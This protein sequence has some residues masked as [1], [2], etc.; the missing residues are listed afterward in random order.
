MSAADRV[1]TTSVAEGFGLVFLEPWLSG[2]A[3][4][5][6]DLPEITCDF[7]TAGLRFE[8]LSSRLAIPVDW[9]GAGAFRQHVERW[10]AETLVRY[11]VPAPSADERR[12]AL[13]A[14]MEGGHVDFATLTSVH[15][16]AIIQQVA[17]DARRRHRLR[18]LNA[19]VDAALDGGPA[20][21]AT[22]RHN[23][24]VVRREYSLD[25]CGHRLTEI[26][27]AALASPRSEPI[28]PLADAARI[29]GEF[30]RLSRFQPIR[31]EP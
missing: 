4:M 23:A 10:Y 22:V 19:W 1:L 18:S 21:A 9:I 14:L 20:E 3:L 15:Q 5:G 12:G 27:R 25:A 11:G 29:L 31:V 30:L 24:D 16:A 7:A 6:R 8:H 13:D 26:Y 28:Q 2:Q 17:S